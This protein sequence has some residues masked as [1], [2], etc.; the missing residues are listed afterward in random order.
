M[1]DVPVE[2]EARDSGEEG[3]A[4]GLQVPEEDMRSFE[5]PRPTV[6]EAAETDALV[7]NAMV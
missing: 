4:S 6:R 1:G 7:G 5:R 3:R 2:G